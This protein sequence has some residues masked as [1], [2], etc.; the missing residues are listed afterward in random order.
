MVLAVESVRGSSTPCCVLCRSVQASSVGVAG[1]IPVVNGRLA[2]YV[3]AY[4]GFFCS[5]REPR[6]Q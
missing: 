2:S 6:T 5:R 3:I 4:I 1:V